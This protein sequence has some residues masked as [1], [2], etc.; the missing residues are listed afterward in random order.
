MREKGRTGWP[1]LFLAKLWIIPLFKGKVK[2]D[3]EWPI[4]VGR[5]KRHCCDTHTRS[6]S[7]DR[8]EGEKVVDVSH[9]SDVAGQIANRS[10][11]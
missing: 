2:G 1:N 6:R 10:R 9:G 4:N 5:S 11:P 3:L 8:G 7:I